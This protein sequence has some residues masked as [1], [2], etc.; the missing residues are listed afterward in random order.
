MAHFLLK[1]EFVLPVFDLP[2]KSEVTEQNFKM[3]T[4]LVIYHL[5]NTNLV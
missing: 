5:K 4:N 3:N 1:L 2:Q